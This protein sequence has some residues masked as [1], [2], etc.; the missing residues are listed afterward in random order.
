MGK[1]SLGLFF[2]KHPTSRITGNTF[3]KNTTMRLHLII[4]LSLLAFTQESSGQKFLQL[5]KVSSMRTQRYSP[6]DE[7]T[8]Q[9][10]GGQ[11]YT[12][13]IEDLSH[14]QNLIIFANGHVK[15][16]DIIALRSFKP[17]RW[18]KPIGNQLY[19]FAIAWTGFALISA[20]VDDD[21][22][23]TWGDAS[24]AATSAGVGALLKS[25]F[26]KRTYHFDKN[27]KGEAKKWRLRV[28]DLNV[29]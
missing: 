13:I 21:D 27:K 5:E 1:S 23:Y 29:K 24:V 20:A 12:R 18:S 2:R 25:L 15:V 6:G 16:E 3:Q 8:F 28:L 19:N 10:I 4:T 9:L 26:R 7:I 17:R 22:S 14:D 11:W